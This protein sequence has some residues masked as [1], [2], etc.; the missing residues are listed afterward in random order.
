M[1]DQFKISRPQIEELIQK[2]ECDFYEGLYNRPSPIKMLPTYVQALPDGSEQGDFFA[3]DLGGTNFRVLLVK[4]NGGRVTMDQKTFPI[5]QEIMQGSSD[6][7]F[8]YIA[9]CLANFAKEKLGEGTKNIGTVGF[10]FSFPVDQTSLTSGTL[11][12]WT[13][14]FDVD[15]VVDEDIVQLLW[16]AIKARNVSIFLLSCVFIFCIFLSFQKPNYS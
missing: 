3:L 15:G 2:M 1:L 7:L 16:K 12:K 6:K 5:A 10:T 8:G 13:K 14:G 9:E 11:I 4:L